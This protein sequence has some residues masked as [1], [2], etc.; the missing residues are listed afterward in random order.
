M[1]QKVE[2]A[3]ESFKQFLKDFPCYYHEEEDLR[4][5]LI[6]ELKKVCGE[7]ETPFVKLGLVHAEV[8]LFPRGS[9]HDI[10]VFDEHSAQKVLEARKWIVS[11]ERKHLPKELRVSDIIEIKQYYNDNE[12]WPEKEIKERIEQAIKQLEETAGKLE[13]QPDLYLVYVHRTFSEF[14]EFVRQEITKYEKDLIPRNIKFR[15]IIL[16]I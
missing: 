4:V 7:I 6:I 16:A 13:Y 2:K 15:P 9:K 3:I 11:R 12:K 10:V 8:G 14:E 1:T 5:L